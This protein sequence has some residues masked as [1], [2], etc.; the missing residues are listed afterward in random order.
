MP[1]EYGG[2]TLMFASCICL[3]CLVVELELRIGSLVIMIVQPLCVG[4]AMVK[5]LRVEQQKGRGLSISLMKAYLKE[6]D[7]SPAVSNVYQEIMDMKASR[8][9][10]HNVYQRIGDAKRFPNRRVT[11][12]APFPILERS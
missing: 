4:P 8:A 12:F 9:Q 11:N 5:P 1:L 10:E 6:D 7:E 2:L 3:R